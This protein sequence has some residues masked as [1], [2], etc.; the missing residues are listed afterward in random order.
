MSQRILVVCT[1]NRCRS[2]MAHGWLQS[3]LGDDAIVQS[4]GTDPRACT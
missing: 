3:L 1:G 4:A 2:Q